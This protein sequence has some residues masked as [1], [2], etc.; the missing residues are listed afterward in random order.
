MEEVVLRFPHLSE[1]I[2]AQ[3]DNLG[4]SRCREVSK[5]WK[6]FL[7]QRKFFHIRSIQS[8]FEKKHKIE[9]P[10]KKFFNDSN[11]EMIILLSSAVKE[12]YSNDA[13]WNIKKE[14]D[15]LHVAAIWGQKFLYKYIKEKVGDENRKSNL[16]FTPFH[17]AAESGHLNLWEYIMENLKD[18]I[19][20]V[21]T[22]LLP[23]LTTLSRSL[24]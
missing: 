2:F 20:R 3:L 24:R 22:I 7:D 8:S 12:V 1:K 18:S 9:E 13:F 23:K 19:K 4:L 5:T 17:F 14:I 16:G 10:W 6:T 11:T 15:P 21:N